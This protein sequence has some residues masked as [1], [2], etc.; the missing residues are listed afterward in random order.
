MTELRGKVAL[1]TGAG[2]GSG[3]ALA[4]AFAAQGARVAANDITPVNVD[5]VVARIKGAGAQAEPF[6]H[7]ISRKAAAQALVKDV[8]D[9]FGGID[10]L[11]HHASVEPSSPLLDMDEWDWHRVLDVN[12]TA[13]FLMI[14]S[15]G[16]VM[17]ARGG[18]VIVTLGAA[19]RQTSGAAAY[20]ASMAGMESLSRMAADELAPYGVRFHFVER[21]RG[22]VVE[23]VIEL[24][25]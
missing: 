8:E 6:I 9:R 17:R 23:T 18:G 19:P 11:I 24:C 4:E 5:E 1:I 14:Q 13:A 7:D 10:I 12:L 3:A 2:R 25:R 16:R 22:N 20:L 21:N 15:V